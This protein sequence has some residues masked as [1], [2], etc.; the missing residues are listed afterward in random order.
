VDAVRTW[1]ISIGCCVVAAWLEGVFAGSGVRRQLREI[2]MPGFAPPFWGWIAIGVCYYAM[3]LMV[4]NRLLRL[5][6]GVLK[7]VGLALIGSVLFMN[8]LWNLFFFRRRDFR[9]A[10]SVS[11]IYTV[12]SCS[13]FV[14]LLFSDR[15]AALIFVPYVCYLAFANAFG[16]R[17]WRLN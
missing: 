17:V 8:A 10:F 12:L 4:L 16:Y 1:A 3:A 11:L 6:P 9:R 14:I 7:G 5:P 15:F 13:L 2:R